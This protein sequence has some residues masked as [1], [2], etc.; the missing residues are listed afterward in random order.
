MAALSGRHFLPQ[1]LAEVQALVLGLA[2][3]LD[4][5]DLPQLSLTFSKPSSFCFSIMLAFNATLVSNALATSSMTSKMYR[6]YETSATMPFKKR[7]VLFRLL[8]SK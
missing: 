2:S 8:N 1:T 7:K 5:R 4:V 3:K 6:D